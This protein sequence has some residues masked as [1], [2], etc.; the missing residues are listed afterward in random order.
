MVIKKRGL[1]MS[2]VKFV[3]AGIIFA[4]ALASVIGI[5]SAA[6]QPFETDSVLIKM[7]VTKGDLIAKDFT[8]TSSS[9]GQFNLEVLGI[10]SAKLSES[11]LVLQPGQSSKIKFSLDTY[12]LK[13]GVYAG[14]IKISGS[15]K[16]LYIPVVIEVQSVDIFYNVNLDVAPDYSNIAKG[17]KLVAQIK[18]IDLISGGTKSKL[19]ASAVGMEYYV[20][21][22]SGNKLV[23]ESES[24]T[25][26][27]SSQYSKTISFP[28]SVSEGNYVLGVVARYASSVGTASSLFSIG[29]AQSSGLFGAGINLY[30]VIGAV[31]AI[32]IGAI[33]IIVYSMK[34]ENKLVSELERY[35]AQELRYQK[36][37][38]LAQARV[39]RQK[40]ASPRKVRREIAHKVKA[41]KR[42]HKERVNKFK[43]LRKAG[44]VSEMRKALN[45]WKKEGY[46]TLEMN[47]R[48]GNLSTPEMKKIMADWKAGKK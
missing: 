1:K 14:S 34:G 31:I 27:G 44:K 10:D 11:S 39:M 8:I 15:S 20:F 9:G 21:D 42:K 25:V 37:I 35:H 29:K 17:G 18:V 43:K 16:I 4:I 6:S 2:N 24:I 23:S 30:F 36:D 46:Y 13:E 47:S 12:G 38:L 26:D 48:L 5:A 3:L 41:L 40:G 28:E 22:S 7:T 19:N 32:L 33:V 45:S